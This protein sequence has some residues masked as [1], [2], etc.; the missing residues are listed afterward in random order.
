ML[1]PVGELLVVD[2]F[3]EDVVS[4]YTFTAAQALSTALLKNIVKFTLLIV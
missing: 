4:P 1:K 2:V 3:T